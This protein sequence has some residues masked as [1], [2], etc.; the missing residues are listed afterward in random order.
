VTAG[1]KQ[2][3]VIADGLLFAWGNSDETNALCTGSN[4]D[5][6]KLCYTKILQGKTFFKVVANEANTFALTSDGHL[7]GWGQSAYRTINYK[8]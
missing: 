3:T 1:N 2:T 4:G 8:H 7:I 5:A 6:P